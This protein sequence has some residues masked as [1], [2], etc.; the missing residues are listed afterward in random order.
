MIDWDRVAQLRDEIGAEDF[1]EVVELFLT[2][3]DA[4]IDQ[5]ADLP[6]VAKPWEEQLHFLKGAALNLGFRAMS[7]LCQQGEHAAAAGAVAPVSQA[8]M[9]ATFDE[10]RDAFLRDLPVR[11][12]A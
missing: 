3:V 10:S 5:M 7:T 11:F 9:R 2:E 12:A 8:Q 1:D 6:A 4:A